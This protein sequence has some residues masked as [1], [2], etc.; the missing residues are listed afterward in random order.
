[1]S[2]TSSRGS[3]SLCYCRSAP[4]VV[5]LEMRGTRIQQ[6]TARLLRRKQRNRHSCDNGRLFR[7]C[8][9]VCFR[10]FGHHHLRR[11][12]AVLQVATCSAVGDSFMFNDLPI[13]RV[14]FVPP[15][16]MVGRRRIKSEFSIGPQ[17]ILAPIYQLSGVV[18]ECLFM[19]ERTPR[20]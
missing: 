19:S 10:T 9:S 18:F 14:F 11:R 15:C 16:P 1:L 13:A 17:D 2:V 6:F 5:D 7:P 3:G 20:R 8:V 4:G 12:G